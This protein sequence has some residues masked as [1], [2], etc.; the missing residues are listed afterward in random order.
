MVIKLSSGLRIVYTQQKTAVSYCG[1]C[2]GV[3]SRVEDKDKGAGVVHFIEHLLFKG[4]NKRDCFGILEFVENVGG[5]INA[6]TTKED[7]F[8][9]VNLPVEYTGRAVDVLFDVYQNSLF[10]KDE[11]EKEKGVVVDEI[12]SYM[13]NPSE[14]IMDEFEEK[15]FEGS[16]LAGN[17]LGT[18]ACVKEMDRQYVCDFYESKYD[19]T[20]AVF[21][22]VGPLEFSE[23]KALVEQYSAGIK[24]KENAVLE[25][26][27]FVPFILK[28]EK[29]THQSHCVIGQ[30][31]YSQ[32][33]D[34]RL[35]MMFV[36][37]LLG[38]MSF[39]SRLSYML[40]EEYGLTY[41][42]ETNYTAFSDIGL[43]SVYY[44]TD[45]ENVDECMSVIKGEFDRMGKGLMPEVE[46]EKW[47][48]QFVGQLALYYDNNLNVMLSNAKSVLVYGK[49]EQYND[50]KNRLLS[51]TAEDILTVSREVLDFEKMS[52]LTY[53]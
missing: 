20:K 24:A 53:V 48:N 38:G 39:N 46:L 28:E 16:S 47:K 18:E 7:T 22:Y 6:Y 4:T 33:E 49:E 15:I 36:N 42:I 43:F 25:E 9:Y 37:N 14:N 30:K 51:V 11:F 40:R 8:V 45:P 5:D 21:S 10:D 19:L 17:I 12:L 34:L 50:I 44:G 27:C 41:N 23:V 13:D 35:P 1:L 29:D 2:V 52:V 26:A 3:G 31:A 32:K